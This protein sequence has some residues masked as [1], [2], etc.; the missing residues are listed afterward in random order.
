MVLN[1]LKL[2]KL[3]TLLFCISCL[4][5][6]SAPFIGY[7]ILDL[8]SIKY[9]LEWDTFGALFVPNVLLLYLKELL[10]F[11]GGVLT[12]FTINMGRLI[13]MLMVG[14]ELFLSLLM[15]ISVSPSIDLFFGLI[16]GLSL[17]GILSLAY[18]SE[19]NAHFKK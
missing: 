19:L 13:L 11:A 7:S 9:I 18:C 1:N 5:G 10:Y 2:F 15:G 16:N 17:G 12:F 14:V 3:L 6:L 8:E 4:W